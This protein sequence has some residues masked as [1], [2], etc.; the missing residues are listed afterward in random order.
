MDENIGDI[1]VAKLAGWI[2]D[3]VEKALVLFRDPAGH[4]KGTVRALREVLFPAGLSQ[5]LIETVKQADQWASA[6]DRPQFPKDLREERYPSWAQVNFAERPVFIHPLSGEQITIEEGLVELDYRH[7]K[8][9]STDHFGALVIREAD[10]SVNHRKTFL[11]FWRFGI[12]SPS[13]GLDGVWQLLPADTRIPDHTIWAHLDLTSAFATALRAAPCSAPALLAMSFGPV[14]DF[15][16]QSRTTSD[17]WAGS[18]L[19]SRI[20]WEGLKVICNDLGPDTVIYPQL[21]GIPQVD[22]WLEK[23]IQLPS[24]LFERLP[25]RLQRTDANPLF[26][27]ALPNRFVAVVPESLVST[28]VGKVKQTVKDWVKTKAHQALA[29]LVEVSSSFAGDLTHAHNQ[30]EEQIRGFPE[31]FWAAVPWSLVRMENGKVVTNSL[32][33]AMEPFY[34][35]GKGMPG[36]LGSPGWQVL[37]KEISAGGG[38][39]YRPNPGVLYPA[40]YELLDRVMAASKSA[41]SFHQLIQYGYRCSLCGER[42]WLATQEQQLNIHPN[43]RAETLWSDIA[44]KRREWNRKGEHLCALCSL[45]RLWPSLFLQEIREILP[46]LNRYVVSTHTMSLSTSLE[47]WLNDQERS[48]LPDWLKN[49]F[50]TREKRVSLPRKL[51]RRIMN[52]LPE[53]RGFVRG[54]PLLVDEVENALDSPDSLEREQAL[55]C[56]KRLTKDLYD[57]FGHKPE[58]YYG[59]IL[60]DGDRLGAWI[61]GQE[62]SYTLPYQESWHPQIRASVQANLRDP[63]VASY[64]ETYRAASPARHMAI[65]NALNTFSLHLARYV[66]ED[67]FKGKLIYSG[68]DD[69]MAM[70]SID[71][72]LPAM[73][74][75]RIFYSGVFPGPTTGNAVC[76][77]LGLPSDLELKARNGY[78]LYREGSKPRLQ[79]V[80]GPKATASIGAVVAHHMAPLGR[81]LRELRR[82]E[83]QAKSEGGRDAFAITVLKRAGGAV[84]LVCPWQAN[85]SEMLEQS[86]MGLLIRLRNVLAEGGLSRRAPYLV[87]EWSRSLPTEQ[88]V[89]EMNSGTGTFGSLLETSLRY[90][91]RRQS[92]AS[93]KDE[94]GMLAVEIAR[95]AISISRHMKAARFQEFLQNFLLMAEFLAREGRTGSAQAK[96]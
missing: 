86:P 90:Q 21:R 84:E 64:L 73:L 80:M 6:A 59:F 51:D 17:L 71:D 30:I 58:T 15:I 61:S 45:K 43:Q 66:C 46:E 4:E 26:T 2:H 37:S 88:T 23:E 65:S 44:A 92:V 25:Y 54:L 75:L 19:L 10:G 56:Q 91:F 95:K 96:A 62:K 24:A 39:F 12:E 20:V 74:T 38:A 50:L 33:Q 5:E 81:V 57:L 49:L 36:F 82:A 32:Q 68:G 1:W 8:A 83:R 40:I 67:L 9:I 93:S 79:R 14:Q 18:H 7:L 27:A 3:P 53:I 60:M 94:N 34:P 31:T 42:E 22:L 11:S 35:L 52:E 69:V 41:R 89:A 29:R 78:I 72:L 85:E 28:I 47:K 48:P 70:M 55:E 16:S 87:Q 63:Q 77:K 13:T 76:C